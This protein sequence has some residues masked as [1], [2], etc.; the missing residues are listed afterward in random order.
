M[1]MYAIKMTPICIYMLVVCSKIQGI[2]YADNVQNMYRKC[3]ERTCR[4]MQLILFQY[5][6]IMQIY[7]V[8]MQTYTIYMPHIC[9]KYAY[10]IQTLCQDLKFSSYGFICHLDTEICL[11]Y[12]PTYKVYADIC[13]QKCAYRMQKYADVHIVCRHMQKY[14]SYMQ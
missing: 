1:Q 13:R 5:A 9:N 10:N 6:S 4:N 14:V 12:V 11:Q 2:L 3:A 8:N 7:A